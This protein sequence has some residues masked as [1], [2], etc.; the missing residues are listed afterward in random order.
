MSNLKNRKYGD[1]KSIIEILN[2]GFEPLLTNNEY[3][4]NKEILDLKYKNNLLKGTINFINNKLLYEDDL[5]YCNWL[6]KNLDISLNEF[7]RN[8]ELIK[9]KKQLL[10]DTFSKN[11]NKLRT[12]HEERVYKNIEQFRNINIFESDLTRTFKCQDTEH[13]YDII[14]VVTYYTEI[15]E[16]IIHNGFMCYGKKFVFYTAGA[17]QTR[18]KKSTFVSEDKLKES[19]GKLFCGLDYDKINKLGGMN[20]NKFL[21]YT[22]LPQTNSEIWEDFNIDRAIVIEDIEFKIPDQEVRFIY[23]ETPADKERLF[24]LNK[25]LDNINSELKE[26]KYLKSKYEK[27][28]KR[29]K[30]EIEKEKILKQ[31]K[32]DVIQKIQDLKDTYHKTKIGKMDVEIPFTDGFGISLKK[33]STSMVRL[34]F[35]KGLLDYCS[36]NKFIKY[37]KENNVKINEVKDIYGKFH[38]IKDIDYIFTKSQF[39]MWKYYQNEYD[40]NGNLVR[41][42]WEVYKDYFKEYKCD[43]CKCNVEKKYIKLNAKTNYQ[44]LQTL[45]TEMTDEEIKDLAREDIYNLEGIGNNVQCMLNVLGANEGKNDKLN[46]LQKSLILYPEMLKDYYVKTLLKN[47]KNSM[48]KKFKSGKFNINGAYTYIIPDTLACL[49]WWFNGERD[50]DKLGYIKKDNIYC[51]LFDNSEE[52][53]C[54]RSPHLDHAHCIRKNQRNKEM[55]SWYQSKGAYVGVNDIISK[56]LMNDFDGDKM[57]IHNNKTI[58]NCAKKFQEKYKM[59]PNYY[60]MPKANPEKLSKDSLFH[61][62]VMAYHHG[63]IGTPSNEIT[64]VFAQLNPN[65]TKEEIEHAIEV[66]ALRTA[67]V[68]YT[69]D[70]AKTLYKPEI[71]KNV[72]QKYKV[73]SKHK[74]PHFFMYAKGKTRKQVESPTK[75]N[76]DRIADIIPNKR[77]VFKDLLGKYSYKNLMSK[78]VDITTDKAQEIIELYKEVDSANIRKLANM[79]ITNMSYREKEK[80]YMLLEFDAIK[81]KKMFI[82]LIGETEDYITNILVKALQNDLNKDTLWKLFGENIYNNLLNNIGNTKICEVCGERFEYNINCKNL[83]KYCES[84]AKKIKNEQNKSYYN[85]KK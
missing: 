74:V 51:K 75:C 2:I 1:G 5:A 78:D 6:N 72:L 71:P 67:D 26:L 52:V 22:S 61:G 57:L 8:K 66:V 20:T 63:N 28:Y 38:N 27:G 62:I 73:Y 79:N 4:I 49:Q 65:S 37:C 30:E 85:N 24:E 56:L 11:I 82:E 69:I 83:P 59:I 42:G 29:E 10:R 60:D 68:N 34:P 84:C 48:I 76:I 21:A 58:V 45:T 15:F 13:S 54:I 81:Q 32:K 7:E 33:M 19:F 64:K 43:A 17:G 46:Y 23:T 50:L 25:E 55:D 77:I 70:Y 39:K 14:S 36:K 41:T 9:Y 35:V 16:N 40:D 3:K 44:M 31:N 80:T 18:N 53:D 12:V 47:T